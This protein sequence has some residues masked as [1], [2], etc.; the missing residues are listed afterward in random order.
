MFI[1]SVIQCLTNR[2]NKNKKIFNQ[3]KS[4]CLLLNH[5]IKSF[6]KFFRFNHYNLP[7]TDYLSLFENYKDGPDYL[8]P[9]MES[10]Y[11]ELENSFKNYLKMF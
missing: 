6:E 4:I 7:N 3:I 5:K 10:L 11:L 1:I 9:S 2:I 8:Q